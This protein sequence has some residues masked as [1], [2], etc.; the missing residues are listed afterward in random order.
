MGHS[1]LIQRQKNKPGA[2]KSWLLMSFHCFLH[3]T[4]FTMNSCES[5]SIQRS[6]IPHSLTQWSLSQPLSWIQIS[7]G[8]EMGRATLFHLT[9]FW[10]AEMESSA[11]LRSLLRFVG[12]MPFAWRDG[13]FPLSL[14]EEDAKWKQRRR[15]EKRKKKR[16]WKQDFL[17]FS[18][19]ETK[20]KGGRCRHTW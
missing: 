1:N 10:E 14:W 11:L 20:G 9:H 4:H 7:S 12:W 2:F 13:D 19:T 17:Q 18:R 15:E 6:S 8:S 16:L 5:N 3:W